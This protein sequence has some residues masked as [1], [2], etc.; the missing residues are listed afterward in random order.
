[1]RCI[2]NDP[3]EAAHPL[4]RLSP[5]ATTFYIWKGD[6]SFVEELIECM[7]PYTEDVSLRELKAKIH[8][9]DPSCSNDTE[10][11]PRKSLLWLRDEVQNL[12]CSYKS[13]HDAVADLIPIYAYTIYFFRIRMALKYFL[14]ES[15]EANCILNQID[16]FVLKK[17]D[18][19]FVIPQPPSHSVIDTELVSRGE[20][21]ELLEMLQTRS[22]LL[23]PQLKDGLLHLLEENNIVVIS[24]ETGC[25][26][27]IQDAQNKVAAFAL[28]HLFPDLLVHFVLLEP[29]ASFILKLKEVTCLFWLIDHPNLIARIGEL[30]TTLED[31]PE[32]RSTD[33]VDS[34]ISVD[35]SGHTL[36]ADF[37]DST[38]QEKTQM[39][40]ILEYIGGTDHFRESLA[41]TGDN[42]LKREAFVGN[43]KMICRKSVTEL[44]KYLK[45]L[46]KKVEESIVNMQG[47][48]IIRYPMFV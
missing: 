28:H 17:L 1:M 30:V 3:K 39:P 25:G 31:E 35:Q 27:T 4:E 34:L 9:Y 24:G 44:G 46:N 15:P 8:A 26:K 42:D 38:H 36:E 6:G 16:S 29:Y 18:R 21:E 43:L 7:T 13:L 10:M 19:V 48:C 32:H 14:F 33:F 22:N 2:F 5:E 47:I 37:M 12:P 40:H 41:L 20:H 45:A 11:K 23:V